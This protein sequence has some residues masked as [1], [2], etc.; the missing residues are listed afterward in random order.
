[1]DIM[2]SAGATNVPDGAV[3]TVAGAP[4]VDAA[5]GLISTD[6]T[7]SGDQ[8]WTVRGGDPA[9]LGAV[10]QDKR[11]IS[12]LDKLEPGSVLLAEREME[13]LGVSDGDSLALAG[14][15]GDEQSFTVIA[16][17]SPAVSLV[18]LPDDLRGLDGEAVVTDV[19][20][21]FDEGVD[22]ADG[23]Y[24]VRE[25]L[26]EDSLMVMS[27][28]SQRAEFE[29]VINA[30]L[31]TIVGLLAV[32]VVIAVIGV[33]NT[34][35]LSVIERRRESATL[36]AIGLSKAQLRRMLAVEGMLIAAVGAVLGI[37]IGLAFGWA[38]AVSSLSMMGDV[39][40][41]VPW[42]EL[43]IAFV[44]ALLAGLVASVAPARTAL[45]ASPVEALAAE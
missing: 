17:Q 22:P 43:V 30:M 32:A 2:V 24:D 44:A 29:Q 4:G 25:A 18:M 38:G 8:F 31:A 35:S 3:E 42:A 6:A 33:A 37:V 21:S 9:E 10:L 14:P 20:A 28:A 26:S 40:L 16:A 34:L 41:V 19:W 1:M 11:A 7:T 39:A 13:D 23:L 15:D 45:K 12:D 5:V 36:R 27:P